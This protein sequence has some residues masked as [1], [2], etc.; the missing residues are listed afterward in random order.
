M[1]YPK[2]PLAQQVI[3]LCAA[4]GVSH[5]VISPGS[6]NAPLT[7]GF[8]SHPEIK[9]YSIVDE[10]CAAFFAL[11]LWKRSKSCLKRTG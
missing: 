4:K 10:R 6:R 7:I 8:A 5:V 11:D 2:I 1:S 9:T 3:Q